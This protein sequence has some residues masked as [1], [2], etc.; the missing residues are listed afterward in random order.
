M[1]S[2]RS[3]GVLPH[4]L[5]ERLEIHVPVAHYDSLQLGRIRLQTSTLASPIAVD[6]EGIPL[7]SNSGL[8][9]GTFVQ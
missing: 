5:Q 7:A 6:V 4:L 3:C 2:A 9:L 8:L 1:Q